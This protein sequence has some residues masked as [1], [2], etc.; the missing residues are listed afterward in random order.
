MTCSR[1]GYVDQTCS[2]ILHPAVLCCAISCCSEGPK[3]EGQCP[4]AKSGI[5]GL[6]GKV[7]VERGTSLATKGF[8][9]NLRAQILH[10]RKLSTLLVTIFVLGFEA[11]KQVESI[12]QRLTEEWQRPPL[13][14]LLLPAAACESAWP[15]LE[16]LSDK[17]VWLGVYLKQNH[18]G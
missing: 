15:A 11:V 7:E 6:E 17:V 3:G 4:T 16:G 12:C 5:L 10:S 14:A 13:I 8:S 18:R 9:L 1:R 2:F